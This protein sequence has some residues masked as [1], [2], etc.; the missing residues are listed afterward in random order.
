MLIKIATQ[1]TVSDAATALQAAVQANHFGV[2]Q[3]HNLKEI[4]NKKGVAFANECLIFEVCQPQ[5]AKKVLDENMSVCTALP[6]RISVY[7][8]DGKTMLATLKPSTL[9]AMFNTPQLTE[10][11][12]EVEDSIVKIMNEAVSA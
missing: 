1:K 12:Q 3:V 2:M 9:L 10:V 4:M 5:Q 8:E 6:C 7:Q 11:A